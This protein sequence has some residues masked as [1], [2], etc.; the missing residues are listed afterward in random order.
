MFGTVIGNWMESAHSCIERRETVPLLRELGYSVGRG[1]IPLC[2]ACANLGCVQRLHGLSSIRSSDLADVNLG[3]KNVCTEGQGRDWLSCYGTLSG[4]PP[5]R[6]SGS[7]HLS[8]NLL[9][10]A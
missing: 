6:V 7:V 5:A 1:V 2:T 4:H 10:A 9:S 8:V 3:G